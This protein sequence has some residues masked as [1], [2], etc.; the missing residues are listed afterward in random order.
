M[1]G[2]VNATSSRR[3]I[4]DNH[5]VLC[6]CLR[7]K[8][9]MQW[10]GGI[11]FGLECEALIMS[12]DGVTLSVDELAEYCGTQAGLLAGRTETIGAETDKLLDEIDEDIAELQERL[13]THSNTPEASTASPPTPDTETV[14]DVT[15]LE[16]LETEL[17]EKQAV[18]EAKGAR[19]Q[20]F[21]DLSEAY[22]ELAAALDS[23]ANDGQDALERV[24]QFEQD[25][26]APAFFDDRQTLL[27]TIAEMDR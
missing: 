9:R 26:D 13:A 2:G 17:E 10:C 21:Q 14:N 6:A 7:L 1:L 18:A 27:E 19:M 24:V 15:R 3:S 12:D 16:E 4:Y 22:A 5:P 8:S 20:A 11:V 25:H 23:S